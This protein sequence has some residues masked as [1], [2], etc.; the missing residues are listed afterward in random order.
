[1]T[2]N[3]LIKKS[4]NQEPFTTGE[5]VSMLSIAPDSE[6]SYLIMAEAN[7]I[8]KELSGNKAEVHA[9]FAL[10]LA[11]CPKNCA[12]CAFA[13]ENRIFNSSTTISADDAVSYA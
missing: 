9:Q 13:A 10:N 12:F 11:P 2:I 1:M 3:D 4:K 7:R 5:L 6:A 8:S